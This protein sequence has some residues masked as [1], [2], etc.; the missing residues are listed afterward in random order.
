MGTSI[1][2]RIGGGGSGD[3]TS[4]WDNAIAEPESGDDEAYLYYDHDTNT[5]GYKVPSGAAHDRQ[6]AIDS[7]SDHTSTIT[8]NNIISANANGL[9][10]DS[11]ILKTNVFNKS[12]DD[13]DDISNGTTYVKSENNFTDTLKSK[14]DGIESGA[15]ADLSGSE[16]KTLYE[17]ELNTNAFTDTLLSKLNGIEANA[18]ADQT[19]SEIKTLYENELNTNAFTDTLLSK[20]NG[21]EAGADVTDS[22]NVNTAG[23]TM[24]AD[25]DISGCS[26][27]LDEDD[28][29]SNSATK[30]ASQQSILAKL[31]S[32]VAA[33]AISSILAD[34]SP[35]LGGNLDINGKGITDEVT[36]GESITANNL[37]YFKASDGKFWKTDASAEATANTQLAIAIDSGSADDTITVL[38][39][40]K[41]TTTGLTAGTQYVSET[42]GAITSTKPTTSG[43]IQRIIGYAHSSTSLFFCPSGYYQEVTT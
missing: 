25:S 11:G 18:T 43:A 9:P 40:G 24:N 10:D 2:T 33:N 23:A 13:L 22:T 17:N 35:Q 15:T 21:I 32:Y 30:T 7:T 42:A 6:H 29:S 39:Y 34:T 5:F 1:D 3:A 28:F 19:G 38:I 31:V 4:I 20:L 16:I 41:H 14:L 37:L 27:F 8:E 36:A 26:W 12:T